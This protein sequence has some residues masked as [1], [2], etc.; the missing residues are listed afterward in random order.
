MIQ[1]KQMNGIDLIITEIIIEEK[2]KI[3]LILFLINA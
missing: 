1:D 2:I 3:I